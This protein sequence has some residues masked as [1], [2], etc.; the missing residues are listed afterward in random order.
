MANKRITQN[1]AI[2]YTDITTASVLLVG[3]PTVDRKITFA[4]TKKYC[5]QNKTIGGSLTTDITTNGST[6]TLTNKTLTNPIFNGSGSVTATGTQL[7]KLAGCTTTTAQ[8]NKL[9]GVTVTP[10]QINR[11]AGVSSNIQSQ[12]N[13]LLATQLVIYSNGGIEQYLTISGSQTLLNKNILEPT[14]Y[15]PQIEQ[16]SI[17]SPWYIDGTAVNASA[18]EINILSGSTITTLNL[19]YLSGSTSNIQTQINNAVASIIGPLGIIHNYSTQVTIT[20]TTHTIT[21]ASIISAMGLT[22]FVIDHNSIQ[23]QVS[24]ISSGGGTYTKVNTCT[25]SMTRQ[26]VS[27]LYQL[28]QITWS[29]LSDGKTHNFSINFKIKQSGGGS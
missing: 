28:N 5:L 25:Q 11:L 17:I 8:L 15:N 24:Q 18:D 6:C 29:G 22:G 20:G 1:T 19:N 3:Q 21:Q 16:L 10:T 27:G 2:L 23:V 26:L 7:N 14:I 9:T 4:Q 13:P 12:L